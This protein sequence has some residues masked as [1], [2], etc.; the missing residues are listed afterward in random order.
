MVRVY[1]AR[2]GSFV[3]LLA[4]SGSPSTERG[5]TPRRAIAKKA[6]VIMGSQVH[7]K[8]QKAVRD[9]VK[10]LTDYRNVTKF[11][12]VKPITDLELA[13]L[14]NSMLFRLVADIFDKQP[15]EKRMKYFDKY[16]GAH[17]PALRA[18]PRAF[19]WVYLAA[20]QKHNRIAAFFVAI[21][22][23]IVEK[24][25]RIVTKVKHGKLLAVVRGWRKEVEE[26]VDGA[27]KAVID[28]AEAFKGKDA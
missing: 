10:L 28:A 20:C 1:L 14:E 15:K 4:S 19:R 18:N 21:W 11:F 6:E 24:I 22:A 17:N 23:K 2:V 12:K 8:G 16:H 27:Q 26:K 3:V 25:N 9:R 7:N 5:S 13:R